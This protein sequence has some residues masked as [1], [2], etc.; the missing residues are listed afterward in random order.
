MILAGDIG[1]TKAHLAVFAPGDGTRAPSIEE[2]LPTAGSA[3]LDALLRAFLERTGVRPARVVLGIAG[4]VSDNRCITTNL[5]WQVDGAALERA[6]GAPVT[7]INDLEATGWGLAM[8]GPS[9]LRT[10]QAGERAEGNR[11]L[12]AAGTGLGE[13]ILHWDGTTWIPM[14]SEGG[15]SDF[16]PRDTLEDELLVW[17][18]AKHGRVSYE[19]VLSGPGLANLYR[20]MRETGRGEEPSAVARAF[21]SASDPAS[22]VSAAAL[23]GSCERA[24]LALERF[25][26]I[27]GAEAGNLALKALALGGVFVGGGIAPRLLPALEGGGFTRAFLDKGRLSP[28]LSR[29][30]IA[31]VLDS[32]TAVW[33]AAAYA[34]RSPLLEARP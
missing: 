28:V 31:V 2:R 24:A 20:F 19:R 15:H 12:I 8:L 32:R 1:G 14:A 5:P 10:L 26:S 7:L 22:V 4:P 6:L 27:Y 33:G 25:V 11:A 30:P 3:S 16:A 17:L 9:D 29:V 13:S 34:R 23:D 18:R 21:D